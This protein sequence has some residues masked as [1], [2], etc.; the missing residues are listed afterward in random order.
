MLPD[1]PVPATPPKSLN[2]MSDVTSILVP[3]FPSQLSTT[4]KLSTTLS[5]EVVGVQEGP[6]FQFLPLECDQC[7]QLCKHVQMKN[8]ASS[9][10]HNNVAQFLEGPPL[11]TKWIT[12]MG[13]AY[14][15]HWPLP[16]QGTKPAIKRCGRTSVGTSKSTANTLVN[17]LHFI[18]IRP[19]WRRTRSMGPMWS[20][21]LQ[22]NFLGGTWMST[23]GMGS[24][25]SNGSNSHAV[26]K[27]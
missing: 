6:K 16:S 18:S 20:C 19:G 24:T 5:V 9:I 1:L 3:K 23:T 4:S 26:R 11:H 7:M 10:R 8:R 2:Q 25:N 15:M 27:G 21:M 22:C 17:Q 12:V 14:F 13:T